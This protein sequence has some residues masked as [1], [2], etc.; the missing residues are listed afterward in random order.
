[1]IHVR[2]P[3]TGDVVGQGMSVLNHYPEFGQGVP[4]LWDLREADL[5]HYTT[6][7]MEQ[8]NAHLARYPGRLNAKSA[9]LVLDQ[10][11]L[12]LAR[13]WSVYRMERFPQERKAFVKIEDAI[14][15]MA[16]K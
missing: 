2:K 14:A 8:T 10:G 5:S 9:S 16:G 12:F 4:V 6:R 1:M 3:L 15:W 13:L 11:A 7:D